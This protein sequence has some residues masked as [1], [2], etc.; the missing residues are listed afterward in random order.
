M[1]C[2][3]LVRGPSIVLS[4]VI[5]SLSHSMYMYILGKKKSPPIPLCFHIFTQQHHM[6][7]M[8]VCISARVR[9]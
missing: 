9:A 6:L 3:S 2:F 1:T 5:Y 7:A 4:G 8:Y